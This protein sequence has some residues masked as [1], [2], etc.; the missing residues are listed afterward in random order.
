V[1]HQADPG[2]AI[3]RSGHSERG[4]GQAAGSAHNLSAKQVK[5]IDKSIEAGE[6]AQGGARELNHTQI[7]ESTQRGTDMAAAYIQSEKKAGRFRG[8]HQMTASAGRQNPFL[9]QNR[10]GSRRP[11]EGHKQKP[12]RVF[13]ITVSQLSPAY[14][15]AEPCPLRRPRWL[16][17]LKM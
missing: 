1:F 11:G 17:P 5:Q 8:V 12:V 13:E 9:A 2:H 16:P 3:E 6:A 4:S 10:H 14:T 7:V 15:T